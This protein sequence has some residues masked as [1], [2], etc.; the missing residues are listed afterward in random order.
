MKQIQDNIYKNCKTYD[1]IIQHAQ[2]YLMYIHIYYLVV[3]EEEGQVQEEA[4]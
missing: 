3:D 2:I 1:Q 4:V